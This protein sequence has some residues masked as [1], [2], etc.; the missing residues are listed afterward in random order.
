MRCVASGIVKSVWMVAATEAPLNKFPIELTSWLNVKRTSRFGVTTSVPVQASEKLPPPP[1]APEPEPGAAS[2]ARA[3]A[4]ALP[5]GDL[6][7]AREKRQRTQRNVQ[8]MRPAR[9]EKPSLGSRL[10]SSRSTGRRR[11]FRSD[12]WL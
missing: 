10:P 6:G 5:T 8:M 11:D 2:G 12:T 1:P 9:C 4:V 3:R 7:G